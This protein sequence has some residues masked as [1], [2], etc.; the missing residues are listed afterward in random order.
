MKF[1]AWKAYH[2]EPRPIID[3]YLSRVGS[4]LQE[5]EFVICGNISS[6]EREIVDADA[7]VGWGI[8]PAVF[9]KAKKLKWIQFGS[10]GIDHTVFPELLESDV[11]LTTMSGI[12]TVPVAEH[13]MGAM[14]ALSRRFDLAMKLQAQR[15]YD[16]SELAATSSEVSG[17]TVGI[18]GLGKIGLSIARMAKSLDMRV[19]GTKRTVTGDLPNV[20][21][22][23]SSD[24]LSEMLTQADYVVIVV[25]LTAETCCLIGRNQ[26]DMMKPGSY[27]INVARGAMLDT[28]ALRDA[29]ISGKLAGA[30]LD[31]FPNEPLAPDS[32]FFN[33]P[34]I[35][36]TPHTAASTAKYGERAAGIFKRN[37]DAFL[38]DGRMIN[39]YDRKRGY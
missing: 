2:L 30:A 10:A 22:V 15:K 39:I 17:K 26:I 16:R 32:V 5:H 35:I 27:I 19:I 8:S 33:I 12:H 25:P 9:A 37:L 13:V 29:L 36:M 7:M 31:V 28:D 21:R 1:V 11:T 38:T 14:L 23:Y 3:D 24:Q 4:Y 18:I 34:N 6:I 20:D